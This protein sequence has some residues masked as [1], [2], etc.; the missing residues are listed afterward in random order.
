MYGRWTRTKTRDNSAYGLAY[1][2]GLLRMEEKRNMANIGR[3]TGVSGQN[4]QHFMSESPWAGREMIAAMQEAVCQ[5]PEMTD[6]VLIIDES[7]AEGAGVIQQYNGRQRT[8]DTSQ[9]W[10]FTA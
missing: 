1:M 3:K 10:V 2:S 6:G 7:G 4:M 8:L 5:R 9:V